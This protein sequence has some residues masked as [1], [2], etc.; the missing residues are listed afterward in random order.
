MAS[1]YLH[2]RRLH[3]LSEQPAPVLHIHSEEVLP[4]VRWDF[5]YNSFCPLP[6]VLLLGTTKKVWLHPLDTLPSDTEESDNLLRSCGTWIEYRN[7]F[8]EFRNTLIQVIDFIYGQWL[9]HKVI[10]K[11]H[12]YFTKLSITQGYSTST[13]CLN[14]LGLFTSL[15]MSFLKRGLESIR[16]RH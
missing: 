15:W 3:S 13:I 11:A 9:F 6:L 12:L 14:L 8:W 10:S 4:H 5:L 2:G 1:E 7:H 16:V